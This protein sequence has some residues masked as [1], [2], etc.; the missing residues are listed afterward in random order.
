MSF[1]NKRGKLIIENKNNFTYWNNI[2]I[3]VRDS[4][5][6]GIP[7]T[8]ISPHFLDIGIMGNCQNNCRNCYMQ[9]YKNN[10]H[11]TFKTFKKII[12][13]NKNLL[14]ISLGGTG[15][16]IDHPDIKEMIQYAR[17]KGIIVNATINIPQ[18]VSD[19]Q[20]EIIDN[21]DAVGLSTFDFS[22][23]KNIINYLSK[24]DK[25]NMN[26]K[27]ILHVVVGNTLP[28]DLLKD[29]YEIKIYD[30]L[31]LAYKECKKI[32]LDPKKK[33]KYF[34]NYVF[35]DD[36]HQKNFNKLLSVLSNNFTIG[37]DSCLAPYVIPSI[38][39]TNIPLD[40]CDGG[41][42]SAY[43]DTEG[44][45]HK[46]SCYQNNGEK[47]W[48]DLY[49]QE[50]FECDFIHS[51]GSK[52]KI[53][54]PLLTCKLGYMTNSSSAS[55]IVFANKNEKF[56]LPIVSINEYFRTNRPFSSSNDKDEYYLKD[57]Y[58]NN[59]VLIKCSLDDWGAYVA[60]EVFQNII[61]KDKNYYKC[62]YKLNELTKKIIDEKLNIYY[63]V[64][65]RDD[66][67]GKTLYS[68]EDISDHDIILIKVS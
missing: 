40:I 53:K 3:Y 6:N 43:I 34:N 25:Y 29:I 37:I 49:N 14:Q 4:Y 17:E 58:N 21:F 31:F 59:K 42:W 46:C 61:Y 56:K 20:H 64:A 33:N 66:S 27:F 32:V 45:Y 52:R 30:I 8:P 24:I 55:Y 65:D 36:N 28:S 54:Q 1:Q 67:E 12:D 18:N 23:K 62:Y 13:D 22:A 35:K 50:Y 11:M 2:C 19:K 60:N 47:N 10:K 48:I 68:K 9:N 44:K 63:L 7:F 57:F 5:K 39:K 41:I 51:F 26:C 38:F 15:N 16:P